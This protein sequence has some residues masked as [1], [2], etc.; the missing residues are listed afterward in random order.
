[1]ATTTGATCCA[2]TTNGTTM[3]ES[4]EELRTKVA[5]AC[6]ILALTGLMKDTLGHVSVR[7]PG[8]D[9]MLIR[10]RG[11]QESGLLFTADEDIRR[12]T[13]D[14]KGPDL[15]GRF[16]PP[17]ELP[18]HGETFK[19]RAEVGCVIH[20]HPAGAVLCGLSGVEFRHILGA[21]DSGMSM[22]LLQDGIPL[23]PRSV[24]IRNPQLAAEMLAA[25]GNRNVCLLR[26][27][28]V[29]VT[30]ATIEEATVRAIAFESFCRL[31]WQLRLAGVT[32]PEMPSEDIAQDLPLFSRQ[33]PDSVWRYYV[34]L[35][36]YRRP[37]G[38]D[39]F[40][41]EDLNLA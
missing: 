41:V 6:R 30:G 11:P 36:D 9:E 24:L 25:M 2:S 12:V 8:S 20:A 4:L 31:S 39:P 38:T 35:L 7:I 22:K 16:S 5:Q 37:V 29:T 23:Y 13:F 28:G 3:A 19:E 17:G 21:Y 14:G 1:M 15:E 10:C 27:H 32:A 34:K 40:G 26:G 18:I 33:S